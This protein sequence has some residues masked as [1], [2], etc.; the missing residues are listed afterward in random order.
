MI[1]IHL[2]GSLRRYAADPRPNRDTVVRLS[3]EEQGT[4]GQVLA[5]VGIDPAE[6]GNIFLNGRLLPRSGYPI[7]LGYPLAADEPLLQDAYLDMA[8]SAGDRVGVFPRN[9]SSVVV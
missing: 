8:V 5:Q 2:F 1:E 9:M 6:V 7:L 3:T 4:V